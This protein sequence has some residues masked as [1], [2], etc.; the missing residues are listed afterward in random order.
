MMVIVSR[1]LMNHDGG[2]VTW[3]RTS[4]DPD[5]QR[6]KLPIAARLVSKDLVALVTWPDEQCVV[7]GFFSRYASDPSRD[8]PPFTLDRHEVHL[9]V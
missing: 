3:G 2:T 5:T 9:P 8:K 7:A 1:R 6:Q 4:P